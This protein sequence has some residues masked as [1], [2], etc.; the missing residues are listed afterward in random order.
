VKPVISPIRGGTDGAML[1]FR[2]LPCP[3]LFTGGMNYHGRYEYLPL[4]SLAAAEQ[5]VLRLMVDAAD[6]PAQKSKKSER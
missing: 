2:Q 1:S 5:V 6:Y 4:K 3:N